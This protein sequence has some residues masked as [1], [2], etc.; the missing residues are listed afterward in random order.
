MQQ[1]SRRKRK[2]ERKAE[3]CD[4]HYSL[5]STYYSTSIRDMNSIFSLENIIGNV[6]SVDHANDAGHIDMQTE[7]LLILLH[8]AKSSLGQLPPEV[9]YAVRKGCNR[10]ESL[11]RGPHLRFPFYRSCFINR[12]A[13]KF[14]NIDDSECMISE[15]LAGKSEFSFVDLC[16]GP[17]G[18]IEYI[19]MK[20]SSI[21]PRV[22]C[23]GFGMTLLHPEGSPYDR[24]NWDIDHLH[25][26]I[27]LSN[28]LFHMSDSFFKKVSNTQEE[29]SIS[30]TT[31]VAGMNPTTPKPPTMPTSTTPATTIAI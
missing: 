11:G 3:I 17:G 27:N 6:C 5:P 8:N 15:L 16:G 12:A 28:S 1:S 14:A 2:Y 23:T 7:Q 26:P 19:V 25:D 30:C 13:M 31:S 4:A 9:L 29:A 20:C 18:F 10:F 21:H 24:C 22:R